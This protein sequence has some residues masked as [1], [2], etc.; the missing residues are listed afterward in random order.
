LCLFAGILFSAFCLL[1]SALFGQGIV[2]PTWT[3]QGYATNSLYT[4][5]ITITPMQ[6]LGNNGN[7]IAVGDPIRGR[8]TNSS[9]TTNLLNAS[10]YRVEIASSYATYA[11]TN[12]FDANTTGAVDG[13]NPLYRAFG[14]PTDRGVFAPS[15]AYGMAIWA[16]KYSGVLTN[17]AIYGSIALRTNGGE[18]SGWVW[19]LTNAATGEG[20]WAAPTGGGGSGSGDVVGPSASTVGELAYFDL[21]TGKHLG[22]SGI[23]YTSLS[24][25]ANWNTNSFLGSAFKPTNTW[26]LAGSWIAATNGYPWGTLYDAAST[27]LNA[28]NGMGLSSQLS[29]FRNTNSFVSTNP[30]T[31]SRLGPVKVDGSTITAAADGTISATTGGGGNVTGSGSTASG[32]VATFN[33]GSA[34]G[35]QGGGVLLANV[36]TNT[37]N[38][39]GVMKGNGARGVT[40][41]TAGSDYVA[42]A[43]TLTINGTSLQITSSAGAQDLSASRTVTLS[44][45]NAMTSPGTLNVTSDQTNQ[46][47]F[48]VTGKGTNFGD[49]YAKGAEVVTGG[50][51]N[52]ALTA[53]TLL[54]SDANK[55]ITSVANPSVNSVATN[56]SSGN[57]GYKPLT[58]FAMTNQL[59]DA[60]ALGASGHVKTG[61]TTNLINSEDATGYTNTVAYTHEGATTNINI[62]FNGTVQSFTVTNGPDVWLNWSGANGSAAVQFTTNVSIHSSTTFNKFLAGSNGVSAGVYKITNGWFTVTSAGGTNGTQLSP[63]IVENQ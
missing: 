63:A 6:P 44:F 51:T 13:G 50:F 49:F 26:D 47:N 52:S 40:A 19:T 1:P 31:S 33:N 17:P 53:S 61:A 27:A 8:T 20:D 62:T 35:V 45:P 55:K 58:D 59:L 56:D 10:F 38:I 7:I 15:F 4:K 14:Q 46:G 30:A 24:P 5:S 39:S 21:T 18:S 43:T 60:S 25:W 36:T 42:P 11:F 12:W 54:Q 3:F 2:T 16:L 9:F 57:L 48:S 28:T 32:E 34:T 37:G 23:L 22:R 29:A 41:A